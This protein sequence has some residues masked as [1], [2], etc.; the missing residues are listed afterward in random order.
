MHGDNVQVVGQSYLL[1]VFNR[2]LQ[3]GQ[4]SRRH[5]DIGVMVGLLSSRALR[6]ETR[7]MKRVADNVSED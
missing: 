1:S 4:V 5:R 6:R 2:S 3:M 7:A